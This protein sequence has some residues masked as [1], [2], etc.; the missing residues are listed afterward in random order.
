[1]KLK[2]A[3]TILLFTLFGSL[4]LQANNA[5]IRVAANESITVTLFFPSEI[6]KVIQPAVNYKFE[7]EENA[8][9]AT[10]VARKG[11]VSNLTVITKCGSIFSFL[12]EYNVKVDNFTYLLSGANAI[13]TLH[14]DTHKTTETQTETAKQAQQTIVER[15]ADAS[16]ENLKASFES[17]PEA[18][19]QSYPSL[20]VAETALHDEAETTIPKENS[21]YE[22]D[23]AGYYQIF[24][25]NNYVQE[26]DFEKIATS[27]NLV[28]LQ[29][30]NILKDQ[31]ELYFMLEIRNNSW[32]DFKVKAL[33][34][35]VKSL[36]IDSEIEIEDL[37]VY[38]LQESIGAHSANN[39]VFVCKD[40]NLASG[41]KIYVLL[42]EAEGKE[43]S[44]MLPFKL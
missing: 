4:H 16:T 44:V 30:N 35:Y 1:M 9:M 32:T 24:C 39:L 21:L 38:N 22:S 7:Y 11:T 34:F 8:S 10:L 2:V 3:F 13:G 28:G 19:I 12:L 41:Q 42:E 14:G 6:T 15:E 17:A 37:F 25:E 31:N 26:S 29:M 36:E 40:F 18:V 5:P 33:K 23:R 20:S 43:R 27:V